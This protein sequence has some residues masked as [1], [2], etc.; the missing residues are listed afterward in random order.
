VYVTFGS[1]AGSTLGAIAAGVREAVQT[2]LA[3]PSYRERAGALADELRAEPAVD[4]AVLLFEEL[5][6]S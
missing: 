3:E 4:E 1:V 2:V 6:R 5:D